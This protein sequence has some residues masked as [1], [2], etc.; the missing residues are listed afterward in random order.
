MFFKQKIFKISAI[1]LLLIS[2]H[3]NADF[4]LRNKFGATELH[5]RAFYCPIDYRNMDYFR[6]FYQYENK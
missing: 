2:F 6:E 4:T 5:I 1:L 3:G